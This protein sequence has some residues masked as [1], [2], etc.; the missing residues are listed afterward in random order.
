MKLND[1]IKKTGLT[2]K[3]IYFYEEEGLINPEKDAENNYREYTG[4]DVN[5]LMSVSALRKLDFSVREIHLI[6]DG[7]ESLSEAVQ[8][9]LAVIDAEI[10]RL[11]KIR[12]ILEE[13]DRKENGDIGAV[14][15][16]AEVLDNES[17]NVAGYMQR[18][19]E[20]IMPGNVGKMFAVHYG[21][22]LNEPLDTEEKETAWHGLIQYLDEQEEIRYP[23]DIREIVDEM[24]GKIGG[25]QWRLYSEKAE[26]VT[27]SVLNK[28]TVL[29]EQEKADLDKEIREYQKTSRY[30]SFMKFQKYLNENLMPFFKGVD[31][32]MNVLSSRYG[33]FYTML[34]NEAKNAQG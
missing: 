25:D 32:Y 12:R 23:E 21:Q 9:K 20:R 28:A 10:G 16:L 15:K 6:L 31:V 13:L 34:R 7:K 27:E 11:Q 33:R 17:K 19:L 26:K 30:Q 3:A 4:A 2:K 5:R 1:V 14:R 22:F 29:S 8:S 24:Y 18:E